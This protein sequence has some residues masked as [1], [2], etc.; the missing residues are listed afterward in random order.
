VVD[1]ASN[2]N[3]YQEYFLEGKGGRF[4]GL[5]TL[6]PS[7]ADCLEVWNPQGLFVPV[8]GMVYFFCQFDGTVCE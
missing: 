3:G 4:I 6:L 2:R 7:R 5:T 1:S 8:M